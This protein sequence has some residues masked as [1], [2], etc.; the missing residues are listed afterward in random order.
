M[1]LLQDNCCYITKL[2][3]ILTSSKNLKSLK[4]Q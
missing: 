1:T 4:T 3:T 2:T